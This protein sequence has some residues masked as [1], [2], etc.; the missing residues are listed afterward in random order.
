[1]GWRGPVGS[2]VAGEIPLGQ[3]VKREEDDSAD[4]ATILLGGP[5]GKGLQDAATPIRDPDSVARTGGQ[6]THH[7]D[8]QLLA[9]PSH[10]HA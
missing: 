3:G 6:V 5:I 8:H 10:H 2:H 9:L 1:M 4:G 7:A